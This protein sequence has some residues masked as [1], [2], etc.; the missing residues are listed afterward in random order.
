MLKAIIFDFDGV[1][2]DSEPVH[3]KMF[4]KVLGEMGLTIS[5]KDYYEIY[6]GM[7]DKGCFSTVLK[8][9]GIDSNLEVIQ[10]LIDKKTVYLMDYIKDNLFIYPGVVDFI[11]AS[12]GKYLLAIASGALRHEIE[13]ILEGAGIR[14]A[15]SIIVSAEDVREGK[16]NPECFNKALDR[17]NEISAQPI[18]T[19]DCLVIEDSIAGVEAAKAA[20]IRCAAVTN[21]YNP[22]R[23]KMADIVVDRIADIDLRIM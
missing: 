3:L 8:T 18:M 12:Y 20:G 6:L 7:D 14:S 10:S 11:E 19:A 23:L 15:F 1:I 22:D 2:T 17:L 5:E 4:Q 13:F 21:T 9:N 16:P